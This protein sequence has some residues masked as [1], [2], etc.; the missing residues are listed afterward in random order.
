MR[1]TV[2]IDDALLEQARRVA[3]ERHCPL[4]DV[5]DEALRLLTY[6]RQATATPRA[7]THLR[8]FPGKGLLPGV[9]L[10]SSAAL[11]DLMEER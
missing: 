1:T 6:A 10:D 3:L 8:T 2:T 5:I 4:G 7:K 9:D 11:A